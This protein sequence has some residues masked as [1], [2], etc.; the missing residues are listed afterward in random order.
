MSEK[1]S[2][3]A[4]PK[5]LQEKLD[6]LSQPDEDREGIIEFAKEGLIS[7]L[8]PSLN[9]EQKAAVQAAIKTKSLK[10]SKVIIESF[11]AFVPKQVAVG[12]VP[13]PSTAGAK[14]PGF[15]DKDYVHQFIDKRK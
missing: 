7:K 15:Y 3:S 5:E 6:A 8:L 1:G 10:E 14:V 4:I 13:V 11:K 12:A 2:S 9:D